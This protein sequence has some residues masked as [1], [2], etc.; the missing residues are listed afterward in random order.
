MEEPRS[1]HWDHMTAAS[2]AQQWDAVRASA[3]ALGMELSGTSGV[4]EETWGG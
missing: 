4:V 3:L 2:A 1:A